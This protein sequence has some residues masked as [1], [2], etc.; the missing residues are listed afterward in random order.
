[1]PGAKAPIR[2]MASVHGQVLFQSGQTAEQ[3]PA[4]LAVI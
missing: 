3:A 2:R 1:M 4:R